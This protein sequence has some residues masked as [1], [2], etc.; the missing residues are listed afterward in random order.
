[1]QFYNY[2]DHFCV[3]TP[4]KHWK[5]Q[6]K[7]QKLHNLQLPLHNLRRAH[8]RNQGDESK[9]RAKKREIDKEKDVRIKAAEFDLRSVDSVIIASSIFKYNLHLLKGIKSE[10]FVNFWRNK[11][12]YSLDKCIEIKECANVQINENLF[13]NNYDLLERCFQSQEMLSL[14]KGRWYVLLSY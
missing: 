7:I 12:E 4:R 14:L 9:Q 1:M 6:H 8:P 10:L 2:L 13:E 11:V 5:N 3:I